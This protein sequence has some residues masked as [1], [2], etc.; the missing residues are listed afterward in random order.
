MFDCTD[1]DFFNAFRMAL[2]IITLVMA[3]LLLASPIAWATRGELSG[4]AIPVLS[5]PR[6]RHH[7]PIVYS[8]VRRW[9]AGFTATETL[10]RILVFLVAALLVADLG[11]MVFLALRNLVLF[12]KSS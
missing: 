4:R 1:P 7:P 9:R 12:E 11:V 8:T 2:E 6:V 3:A 10:G 5:V